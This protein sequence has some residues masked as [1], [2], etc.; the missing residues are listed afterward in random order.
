[1]HRRI[2][3]FTTRS[4]IRTQYCSLFFFCFSFLVFESVFFFFFF[5]PPYRFSPNYSSVGGEERR[6]ARS[7][8]ENLFA[9]F[10]RVRPWRKILLPRGCAHAEYVLYIGD[11]FILYDGADQQGKFRRPRGGI[12]TSSVIGEKCK[13]EAKISYARRRGAVARPACNTHR[14]S[15]L[16]ARE[17]AR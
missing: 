13:S 1:M 8:G 15:A 11:S 9:I 6:V 7:C 12:A 10:S 14:R 4:V 2:V 16:S 3:H 17:G 5:V